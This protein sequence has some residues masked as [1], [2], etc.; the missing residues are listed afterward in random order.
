[1][2]VSKALKEEFSNFAYAI[3]TNPTNLLKMLMKQVVLTKEVNFKY[4]PFS[5][6]TIEPLDTSD[7]WEE[8][9]RKTEKN[10]KKLRTLLA[11]RRKWK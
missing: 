5:D 4:D 10:T 9:N 3:W 7:W 8:F 11:K 2:G 6:V 1:L